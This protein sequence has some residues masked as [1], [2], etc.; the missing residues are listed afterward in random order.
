MYKGNTILKVPFLP[1]LSGR[2]KIIDP[3]KNPIK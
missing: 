3:I 1:N 2:K